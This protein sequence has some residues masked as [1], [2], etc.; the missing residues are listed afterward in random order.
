MLELIKEIREETG[1]G[2]ADIK[3]ALEEAG[4]DK[5]QALQILQKQGLKK[6]AKKE[7]RIAREGVVVSYVHADKK[8]GALIKVLCETDFVAKNDEFQQLANDLAMQVVAMK[9][10]GI[11]PED[12][13][14]EDLVTAGLLTEDAAVTDEELDSLRQGQ[15]LYTQAFIKD[16]ERTVEEVI[17]NKIAT[18]GENI[19]VAE[20]VRF[21]I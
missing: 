3:K 6:A 5:E 16:P 18:I 13:S 14:Q 17:K 8:S 10:L 11:K 4:G 9:P 2:I 7:N 20:F 21:E 15:A 12:I 1:A 19:K